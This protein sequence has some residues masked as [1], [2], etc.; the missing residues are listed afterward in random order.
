MVVSVRHLCF[1]IRLERPKCLGQMC[2]D[3][4]NNKCG[5]FRTFLE[6]LSLVRKV[7]QIHVEEKWHLKKEI[8]CI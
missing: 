2:L 5:S 6:L 3:M 1:G 4:P 7:M 8:M